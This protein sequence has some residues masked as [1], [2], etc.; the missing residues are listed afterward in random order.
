MSSKTVGKAYGDGVIKNASIEENYNFVQWTWI[1][2]IFECSP[3]CITELYI[4]FVDEKK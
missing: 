3:E 4:I 2:D 1:N